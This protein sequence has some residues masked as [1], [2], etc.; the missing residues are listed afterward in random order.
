MTVESVTYISDLNTALPASGDAKSEGDDHLR[1]IKT[2]LK[3]TFANVNGAVSATDEE[4]SWLA[5]ITT[6][7]KLRSASVAN[8]A[9]A[10]LLAASGGGAGTSGLVFIITSEGHSAIFSVEGGGTIAREVADP[11]GAFS[12]NSA[13]ASSTNIYWSGSNSRYEIENKRGSTLNYYI[14][15]FSEA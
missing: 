14:T 15:H 5:G 4:I 13:T 3:N 6:R 8:N 12:A 7:I 9:N 11:A 1:N 10:A 2:A